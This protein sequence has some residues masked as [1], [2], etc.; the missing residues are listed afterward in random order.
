MRAHRARR[1]PTG[2]C[3]RLERRVLRRSVQRVPGRADG[4]RRLHDRALLAARTCASSSDHGKL[5]P[6]AAAALSQHVPAVQLH[7]AAGAARPTTWASCGSRWKRRRSRPCCWSALYRTPAS[8][9]AAWKYFI[10]C[11]V[12]IAQALFGTILLYFAAEKVLGAEGGALLWTHLDEVKGAARAD[13]ARRS[14]SCSCSSATAPRSASCRCTTGCPTRTPK[15]RRRSRRCSRGC[16]STSRCTRSCAAR[17]SSK[18]RCDTRFAGNLMMGFGLLSVVVAAFLLSRQKD[19][20]RLFAYSSIEHMGIITFAFGMGGPVANFAGLLHM[21]VHSL[22]KSAIFFA[23]GHAAQ[24]AGTQIMDDI[25]GL[26]TISPT[27][28]WG[29]MLGTLAIL[30]MPPFGV[31]ASEFLILTTAMREQPWATPF[32]LVALGVAF[33][34]VFGKVQPMVFGETTAKRAAASAGADPGV[35]PPRARA[36]ARAVH[37]AVPRRLVSAGGAADRMADAMPISGSAAR[38]RPRCRRRAGLARARRRRRAGCAR[39]ARLRASAA[40]GWSRCGARDDA[41]SRRAASSSARRYARRRRARLARAARCRRRDRRYPGPVGALPGARARMQRAAFDLLGIARRSATITRPWLCHGAWPVDQFPAAAA[42][43]TRAERGSPAQD[44][45]PFVRVEGDGV[46]EIPVGPV[47]AGIIEPGHFRFSVVGEKVLRLEERLGYM[48]KGIEKR[49]EPMALARRRTASPGASRATRPSPTRGPTAMALEASPACDAAARA[50]CGC[51]RCCSSAS[52]SPTIWAISASSAT[53]P[54]SRSGSR[55][56]RGCRKTCC[57]SNAALFGH[58]YLMDCVVPGGVARDL[59]ARQPRAH[60]RGNATRSKREVRALRDDLRR[61][62]RPAGSLH[63]CGRVTPELAAQLGLTGLAGRASGQACDLRVRLPAGR[64]TTRSTCAWRRTATATSPRASTV[65]FDEIVRIAAPDRARS[66]TALPAGEHRADAARCP[67]T[68]ASASAGSRAGAARC[69]SRSRRGAGGTHPPL[70]SARP[71][72]AEL[73]GARARGDRQHRSRLPA[74]QQ[75]VQPR[76][77]AGTIFERRPMLP[78]PQTDRAHRHQDRAARR[79]P[80]EALRV[81]ARGCSDEIARIARPGARRSA[82]STPA[83]ATAASSRSTRST[84]PYYNLEGL[85]IRFVAS[86][87]HADMLLVTGPGVAAHGDRAAA[88][89]R[90]DARARSSSSRSATAAAPAASSARATRACGR[91]VERDPGRRRGARAARRRRSRS[92]RAS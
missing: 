24:K 92:C 65:R 83:R 28:G 41:R 44:D 1:S 48:H 5:T 25:R 42:T 80:D 43:S 31:F 32:L 91:V 77:T 49:F 69:S 29:L 8:L 53:T 54:A 88:H 71:V 47:H 76:P 27:I 26:I 68:R 87:R 72:V 84:I 85:G 20:K 52:A 70:P 51:A 50:R 81:A 66:S 10:L 62:R 40:G 89:L 64:P 37:P 55:S 2:R 67:R 18:A 12:G 60:A 6:R 16:C 58:R 7:D 90:R 15:A 14:R 33:A 19:V 82:T 56:S 9:E 4:V 17:C 61:A 39:R 75:V 30:G 78:D 74:D 79:A 73:A 13:R 3:S 45:Y 46:H 63:R 22:T 38:A 36:D 21:T 86:P 59:D 57:A 11:G 23:V 35:R 34:A